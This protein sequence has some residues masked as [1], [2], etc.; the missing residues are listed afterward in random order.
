MIGNYE[1][2]FYHPNDL[3]VDSGIVKANGFYIELF[4]QDKDY[5]KSLYLVD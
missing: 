5:F 1:L 2:F 3:F 4:E